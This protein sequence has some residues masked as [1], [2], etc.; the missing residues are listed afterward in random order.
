MSCYHETSCL[1]F[2]RRASDA[3][4]GAPGRR[5]AA[6]FTVIELVVVMIITGI[7]AAVAL[8][9]F[10]DRNTF[11]GRAFSDQ[12]RAMLRYAQKIAIAQ[13]RDVHVRFA[14]A[15]VALCYAA[16]CD[17]ANLVQA[18]SGSNSGSAATLVACA[19]SDSWFCEA[20]PSGVT[21][22]LLPALASTTPF[23]FDA[24]GKPYNFNDDATTTTSLFAV[25]AQPDSVQIVR[26]TGADGKRYDVT[27]EKETGYVH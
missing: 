6:G 14:G 1:T 2:S 13:H 4:V 19:N 24:A 11:D 21:I 22:A 7:L 12:T 23:F 18:P 5:R 8:P 17:A 26:I 10:F 27:I 15:S 3:C 20:A 9:R 16:G 25:S